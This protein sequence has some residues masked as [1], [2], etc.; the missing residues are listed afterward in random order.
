MPIVEN[1]TADTF[2]A[3]VGKH[4]ERLIVSSDGEELAEAPL[5]FLETVTLA[6]RGVS[7]S[8]DAME[9][10][11]E[12]GIPVFFLSNHGDPYASIYAPGLTGTVM[13][14]REQ[15]A[16]YGDG[17]GITLALAFARGKILNQAAF[18]RYLARNRTET[19]V[20]ADLRAAAEA[21]AGHTRRLD[22][23]SERALD[24]LRGPLMAAEGS[25]AQAYWEALGTLVPA[26]YEWPGRQGRGA[27]DPVNQILNYG[28]G[29]LYHRIEQAIMV[30]GLDPYGGFIHTDRPGKPS[31]TL[32]LIE[33]FRAPV[34][35]RAV[36]GLVN[37]SFSIGR[38]DDGRLS[39][40]TRRRL[41]DRVLEALDS[42]VAHQGAKMALKQ[43]IHVQARA[44]A[45]FVRG[46]RETYSPFAHAP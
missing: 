3:F 9:A 4:S 36:F 40:E 24:D 7:I 1:L 29:I 31:L 15:L 35:D 18:L 2:G 16:S 17:R 11:C 44:I 14:R 28:Y 27:E 21:V 32:D 41:A 8:S 25:A 34:V 19:S 37:R 10:C 12:R 20:T 5:L 46:H 22:A 23:L 6:G 26:A 39:A 30:A 45:A 42:E 13:T 43:A 33:E 38:D